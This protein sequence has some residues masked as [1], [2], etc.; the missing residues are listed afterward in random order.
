MVSPRGMRCRAAYMVTRTIWDASKVSLATLTPTA[1]QRR[2]TLAV[3]AV[4]LVATAIVAPFG[5]IQLR[6]MD[7]FIPATEAVI[8]ICDLLIAALLA[9][10]AMTIGSRGLLLLAGGFLF[11][12]L[13]VIPHA[14]TFPAHS[15]R[16]AFLAPACKPPHGF[17]FSGISDCPLR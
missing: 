17:S 16:P 7:G 9:S 11:D 1:R 10:H 8:F 12:A 4:L 6:P 5:A 14:L 2:L 3:V 15:R 13:I